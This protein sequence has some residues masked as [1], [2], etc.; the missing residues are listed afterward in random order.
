MMTAR[1][2]RRTKSAPDAH[3]VV[4]AKFTRS[5]TSQPAR[6]LTMGSGDRIECK[7]P[8]VPLFP[9]SSTAP[10]LIAAV[11]DGPRKLLT[12]S[13]TLDDLDKTSKQSRNGD[14]RA[15]RQSAGP[16]SPEETDGNRRGK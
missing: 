11:S 3:F 5:P 14:V 13:R 2:Q 16:S 1:E 7:V 10:S 12:G 6:R 8:A 9:T 15:L 4:R